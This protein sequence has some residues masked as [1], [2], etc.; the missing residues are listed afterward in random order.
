MKVVCK[1]S[2]LEN[3]KTKTRAS[4]EGPIRVVLITAVVF[5]DQNSREVSTRDNP[6]Q[7]LKFERDCCWCG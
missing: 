6:E 7:V 4:Q 1:R 3:A 5:V 2:A